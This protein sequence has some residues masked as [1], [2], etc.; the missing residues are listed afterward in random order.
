MAALSHAYG[1]PPPPSPSPVSRL[2][3][4]YDA[5]L[6][7]PMIRQQRRVKMIHPYGARAWPQ[8]CGARM[9][10]AAPEASVWPRCSDGRERVAAAKLRLLV[11][12][13]SDPRMPFR[14]IG[15][16][17]TWKQEDRVSAALVCF[18]IGR[19]GPSSA[20]LR[21]IDREDAAHGDILWLA[22]VSDGRAGRPMGMD[23][24]L[25]WWRAAAKLM[26]RTMTHA[27]KVD[28]DTHLMLPRLSADLM[29][30][31]CVPHLYY[32]GMAFISV[33]PR[34]FKTCGFDYGGLGHYQSY[35]CASRGFHVAMPFA[36]GA[37]VGLSSSLVQLVASHRD[38]AH[39][40]AR[41]SSRQNNKT[42]LLEDMALGFWLA[43]SHGNVTYANVVRWIGDINCGRPSAGLRRGAQLSLALHRAKFFRSHA[44]LWWIMHHN[45][46]HTEANCTKQTLPT[47]KEARAFAPLAG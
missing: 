34:T 37:V 5:A 8:V 31:R 10:E 26:G 9:S 25:G 23:K 19:Q 47:R 22:N 16:R 15:I 2:L 7:S 41:Y 36:I 40:V 4:E 27:V 44:Y 20:Q 32:G 6:D 43:Y 11:G 18:V 13:Q 1:H 14:R 24:L 21:Q 45:G 42:V 28:D 30:L 39:F 3:R 17:N 35:G 29:A 38:I 33:N 12:V 46:T